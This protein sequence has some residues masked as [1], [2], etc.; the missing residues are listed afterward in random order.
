MGS[1]SF[2]PAGLGILQENMVEAGCCMLMLMLAMT[3]LPMY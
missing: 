3:S 1:A 2:A